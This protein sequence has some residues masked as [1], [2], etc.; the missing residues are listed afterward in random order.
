MILSPD[1]STSVRTISPHPETVARF[2]Q[3]A[4]AATRIGHPIVLEVRFED[5]ETDF[6]EQLE[7]IRMLVASLLEKEEQ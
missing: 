3:E 5:G 2:R 4:R 6:R 1:K 7:R